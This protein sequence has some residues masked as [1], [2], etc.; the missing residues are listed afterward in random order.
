MQHFSQYI[1]V[2]LLF[3]NKACR[4]KMVEGKKI[5][6]E[7]LTGNS[8]VR[9]GFTACT[10]FETSLLEHHD[11]VEVV[12]VNCSEASELGCRA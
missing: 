12:Q 3:Q 5:K 7:T 9:I 10:T 11:G 8:L 1:E 4:K 6:M 2:Y